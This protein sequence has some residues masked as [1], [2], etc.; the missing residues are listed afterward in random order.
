MPESPLKCV[1]LTKSK[2]KPEKIKTCGKPAV[3]VFQGMTVCQRHLYVLSKRMI[4]QVEAS[5]AS[6]EDI[7][8]NV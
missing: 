3:A 8:E 2:D 1:A 7:I 4:A 6:V 5:G